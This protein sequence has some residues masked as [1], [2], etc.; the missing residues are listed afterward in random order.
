MLD[1]HLRQ[2]HLDLVYLVSELNSKSQT[3]Q[4]SSLS[5]LGHSGTR[6]V[7]VRSALRSDLNCF[8]AKCLLSHWLRPTRSSSRLDSEAFSLSFLTDP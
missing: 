4:R 3:A 2:L 8:F 7:L 6:P 5:V 1:S